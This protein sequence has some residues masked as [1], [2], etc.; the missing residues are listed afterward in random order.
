MG[1]GT[2]K[3]DSD[4]VAEGVSLKSLDAKKDD[5]REAEE[6]VGREGELDKVGDK[7]IEGDATAFKIN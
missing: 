5:E 6:I 1:A 4:D 2:R 3:G 7:D